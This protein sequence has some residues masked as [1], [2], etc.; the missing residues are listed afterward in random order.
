MSFSSIYCLPGPKINSNNFINYFESLGKYFIVAGDLN[1]KHSSWV[2]LSTNTKGRTLYNSTNNSNIN[3]LPPPHPTN[4]PTHQNRRPDIHD[5]FIASI[6]SNCTTNVSNTNDLSS[7]HCPLKF[8]LE[9]PCSSSSTNPQ[10]LGK[11]D[12]PTFQKLIE[13]RTQLN[14]SLKSSEDIDSTIQK[15]NSDIRECIQLATIP[16]T[17]HSKN[18]LPNHIK[19]LLPEKRKARSWW[20]RHKYPINKHTYN[21]LNNKLRKALQQHNSITY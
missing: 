15:L 17:I 1:A 4:W 10:T 3:I 9:I 8:D 19:S 20:Q 6:P 12:W 11:I 21:Q 14:P 2:C 16:S 5:I 13:T 7:D 18:I